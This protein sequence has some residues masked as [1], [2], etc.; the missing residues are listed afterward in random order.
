M[1]CHGRAVWCIGLKFWCQNVGSN[2]GL[3]GCG[4]CV[5]E[6]DTYNRNCFVLRMGHEAV[7]PVCCVMHVKEPRTLIVKEKGACPIVSGF[8]PWASSSVDM[9]A[10][11]IFCIIVIII[12]IIIIIISVYA[13][14]KHPSSRPE[15]AKYFPD[16]KQNHQSWRLGHS[17]GARRKQR[18]GNHID[19]Y[20]ILYE[21][22]A[23]QQ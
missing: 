15:D 13:W 11:Q 3:A 9:C 22:G 4:A 2:P 6:Q 18:H 8:A 10:L 17:Q 12:I 7:G 20:P 5:L 1:E 23:V 14:K 16:Q 19:R 21:S